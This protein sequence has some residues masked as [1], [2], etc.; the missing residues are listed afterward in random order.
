MA[1]GQ[2]AFDL[3]GSS[4][5]FSESDLTYGE[6]RVVFVD[7]VNRRDN[8]VMF[9]R[10]AVVNAR[11]AGDGVAMDKDRNRGFVRLVRGEGD[12]GT[13]ILREVARR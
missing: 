13:A 4:I 9:T 2:G 12:L 7:I 3:C 1:R 6:H 5:V 10:V 11:V 8:A